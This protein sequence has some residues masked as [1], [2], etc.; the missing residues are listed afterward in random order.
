MN[1]LLG[2]APPPQVLGSTAYGGWT[3]VSRTRIP[4]NLTKFC[5]HASPGTCFF[6]KGALQANALTWNILK[7]KKPKT[8]WT[9]VTHIMK[10]YLWNIILN[11]KLHRLCYIRTFITICNKFLPLYLQMIHSDLQEALYQ[12]ISLL[13]IISGVAMSAYLVCS[14]CLLTWV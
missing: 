12:F 7:K 14:K 6:R 3:P 5:G 8:L 2:S 4:L 11:T 1:L 10:K 9:N 13:I